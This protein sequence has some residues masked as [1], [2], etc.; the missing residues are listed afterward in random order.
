MRGS[1]VDAYVMAFG[2]K[3]FNGA[4]KESNADPQWFTVCRCQG[5]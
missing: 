3:T 5:M 2:G 4:L 1:E